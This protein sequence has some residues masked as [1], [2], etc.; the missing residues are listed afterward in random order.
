[1]A[2]DNL[3]A[4]KKRHSSRVEGLISEDDSPDAAGTHGSEVGAGQTG[5][6]TA[7]PAGADPNTEIASDFPVGRYWQLRSQLDPTRANT[8]AAP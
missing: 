5:T 4:A 7:Y 1:M 6:T 3:E 8:Q 2:A